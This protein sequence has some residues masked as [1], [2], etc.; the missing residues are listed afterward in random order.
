MVKM[1]DGPIDITIRST[2]YKKVAGAE[3]SVL[4]LVCLVAAILA[5]VIFKMATNREL[6]PDN[7][8]MNALITAKDFE[9]LKNLL[10]SSNADIAAQGLTQ[11][12][13]MLDWE[14]RSCRSSSV[15]WVSSHPRRFSAQKLQTQY[16]LL[17]LFSWPSG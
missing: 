17:R 7:A 5:N 10:T 8:N 14:R 3:M 4:D 1:L 15:H 9:T 13:T 6:F 16:F 2:V 11:V 12:A